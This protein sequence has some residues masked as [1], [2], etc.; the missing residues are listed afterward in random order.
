[1]A[2][3]LQAEIAGQWGAS[4]VKQLTGRE[5][6]IVR[7]VAAGLRNA[8]VA[9]R[10]TISEA[11]VKSHLNNIFQKLDLRDRVELALY[12]VKH[13]LVISPGHSA[14]KDQ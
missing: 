2:P 11:T 9:Q 7:Y 4:D 1:M 6:E 12:A 13:G 3:A 5:A 8:E 14:A 10:L